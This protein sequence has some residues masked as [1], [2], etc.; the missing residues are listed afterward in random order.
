M[1]N[2]SIPAKVKEKMS[3][4]DLGYWEG[5]I[6][7]HN[8]LLLKAIQLSW[9]VTIEAKNEKELTLKNEEFY[10]S[11]GV[12][13]DQ[14]KSNS[15]AKS[16]K[17]WLSSSSDPNK[18]S[19]AEFAIRSGK[20]ILKQKGSSG[21]LENILSVDLPSSSPNLEDYIFSVKSMKSSFIEKQSGMSEKERMRAS[22]ARTNRLKE[23]ELII[24]SSI[25]LTGEMNEFSTVYKYKYKI[26]EIAEYQTIMS[27]G[28]DE[29]KAI[30][31]RIP[32]ADGSFRFIAFDPITGETLAQATRRPL[33]EFEEEYFSFLL[34]KNQLQEISNNID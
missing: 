31:V 10:I 6:K 14:L 25:V 27:S 26:V 4:E 21:E 11:C 5:L 3:P 28:K 2:G 15:S 22:M 24:P 32:V 19:M 18:Q 7:S 34:G 29:K 9:D 13:S 8:E 33:E 20:L 17:K 16:F 1:I 12:W 23:L 30:M